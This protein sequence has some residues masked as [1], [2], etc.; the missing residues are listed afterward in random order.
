MTIK[1][2]RVAPLFL[3]ATFSLSE[4]ASASYAIDANDIFKEVIEQSRKITSLKKKLSS[5]EKLMDAE[6]SYYYPKVEFSIDYSEFYG[7][8]E[9]PLDSDSELVMSINSTLYS[10][11]S[12]DRI[13]SA[14]NNRLAAYYSLKQKENELYFNVV[15]ELLK[16]ERS[17]TFLAESDLIREKMDDFITQISN[18]V[19]AGVSPVSYLRETQLIKV[20][21][22]DT[23]ATVKS[24]IDSYFTQLYLS[25]GYKVVDKDEVGLP[26]VLLNTVLAE[27]LIFDAQEGVN[28]N[29]DLRSKYHTV[30]ALKH[31]ADA[32]FEKLIVSAFNDT[33]IGLKSN[34][35][36]LRGDV[37]ES[38]AV[39]LRLQYQLFDRKKS[40]TKGAAY[41]TYE[42]EMESLEDE[43][44]SMR[45]KIIELGENYD[46]M[47]NRRDNLLEQ[48]RLSKNLIDS[49][50]KE[51]LVDRIEFI[52][53]V[54]S[55][56]EL[57]RTH[58]TL[59]NNDVKL[60]DNISEY[61]SIIS[62]PFN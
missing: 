35:D 62:K 31:D 29:L 19:T 27:K 30:A 36:N 48:I 7:K 53:M 60:Y 11:V 50:E 33:N 58:V 34:S 22:N 2:A 6:R 23:I 51:I 56:S 41:N 43:R 3:L 17:R 8:Q 59:L 40:K 45:A 20:R 28:S 38:S 26:S 44:D 37:R 14:D 25:T 16:I 1:V 61:R 9:P 55:L 42:S 54:K 13:R 57:V 15:S 32:N 49:Q 18:A 47:M 39:G 21:F 12:S 46:T 5:K 52:D 10:D 24:D 4:V